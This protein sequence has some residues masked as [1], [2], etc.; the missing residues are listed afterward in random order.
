[1]WEKK[2]LPIDKMSIVKNETV[3]FNVDE[4]KTEKI[5]S[6]YFNCRI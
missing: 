5:S 2:Y 3:S 6:T 1:M 4:I